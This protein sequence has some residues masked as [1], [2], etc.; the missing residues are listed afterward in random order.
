MMNEEAIAPGS[1]K[2][3]EKLRYKVSPFMEKKAVDLRS[4]PVG[5]DDSETCAISNGPTE[6][7]NSF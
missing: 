5:W 2:V 1:Y 6:E 3:T 7:K 4:F